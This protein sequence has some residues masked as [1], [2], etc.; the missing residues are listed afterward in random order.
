VGAQGL[1]AHTRA[2]L[3]KVEASEAV[4][5][6]EDVAKLRQTERD[7]GAMLKADDD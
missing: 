6:P 5:A 3:E 2:L 7:L 1:L 4:L